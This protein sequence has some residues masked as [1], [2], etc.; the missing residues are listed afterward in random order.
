MQTKMFVRRTVY[1]HGLKMTLVCPGNC[2]TH[3]QRLCEL[4]ATFI[5]LCY[6]ITDFKQETMAQG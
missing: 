6:M 3:M 1:F 4:N 2:G 5:H